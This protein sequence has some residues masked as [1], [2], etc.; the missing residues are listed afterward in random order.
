M[1]KLVLSAALLAAGAAAAQESEQSYLGGFLE[2]SLSDTGRIV[3]VT[4]FEGALSSQARI[5]TLTVADDAGVWLTIEGAVLDWSRSSLLSGALEVNE[6]SAA[7]ITLTR[8]PQAGEAEL[9]APEAGAFSLPELPVSI[10]IGSIVAERITVGESVLGQP[11][12]GHL[13]ATM[14]LADGSGAAHLAL[15][16]T[17]DG[18]LGEIRLD[19]SYD[20]AT[21][22]LGMSLSAAES[23]G[24][25]VAGLLGI[26]GTPATSF[27]MEG[28]G[29]IEAFLADIALSTAGED[30]LSGKATLSGTGDGGHHLL[31]DL[32]GNLAPLFVPEHAEFLG[33]NIRLTLD[34]QRSATGRVM[35]DALSLQARS[36]ALS[37]KGNLAADGLPENFLLS[38]TLA[39][40]DGNP[41]LLPFG[42]VPTRIDRAEFEFSLGQ[43]EATAWQTTARITGLDQADLAIDALSLSGSGTIGRISSRKNFDGSIQLSADG[44]RPTDPSLAQALGE[45]ITGSFRFQALEG[46]KA[47]R[48][49]DL[50]L[51]GDGFSGS[52]QLQIEGL[53]AALLTSGDLTVT[54]D[55]LS[56][57]ALLADRPL[58]GKGTVRLTGSTSLL[59]GALDAVVKVTAQDLQ[60]GIDQIDRLLAGTSTASLSVLR[61]TNGTTIRAFDLTAGSLLA[62][63][64]GTIATAGSALQG[65]VRIGELAMLDPGYGGTA[66]V[67]FEFDGTP[68]A[69]QLSLTGDASNLRLGLPSIDSLL[70]G[71][72][73]LSARFSLTDG[74][75]LIT[76][77]LLSNGQLTASISGEAVDGGQKLALDG[78]LADLGLLIPNLKGPLSLTGTALELGADYRLDLA[79]RGPGKV[80]GKVNGRIA[81]DFST[82]DLT[83]AGTGQAGLA[84]PFIAPRLIDGPL[85][86]DLR[87]NGPL[88]PGSLSGRASLSNGRMSDPGL[89]FALERVDALIDLA[90]GKAKLA[91]TSGLSSG[92]T[93]RV[94]GPV[95][96]A[97]P[98]SADL[99]V[100]LDRIRLFDPNLYETVVQGGLR[101]AGPLTG[102]ALV[103]GDMLLSETEIRVPEAGIDVAGSMI[104]LA[105]LQEPAEVRATRARAGLIGDS[106]KGDKGS[107]LKGAFRLDL[108]INAPGRIFLRGR[109]IDAELGGSLRLQGTSA[110][111]VPSGTFALIR[112]RLDILGKRLTLD[113]ADLKMEGSFVPVLS[114]AAS[115]D[116]DGVTSSVNID[117]PADDPAVTFSSNP[118]LPQEEV[119]A[120]LLFGRGIDSISALQAAQLAQAVA[121][122]AGRGGDGLIGNLRKNFGLDDLDVVTAEDGTAALT[123]GKYISENIYTEVEIE[124]GG[125]SRINLNL[126]LRPGV[127]L[128]GRVG[129]DG[130]TGVGIFIDRDY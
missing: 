64:A 48:L 37:G 26:P 92:G 47:L 60:I 88:A 40:P 23:E 38:G 120:L 100:D 62:K 106:G 33:T 73:A 69:A 98:Y 97:A 125:T 89:G 50:Q 129:A 77:A 22:M 3:K 18:P 28:S 32:S 75:P 130:E 8:L 58:A 42:D 52:G 54:F 105:H 82:A 43:S 78:R 83:I 2:D 72:T 16:R 4:G 113:R 59:S 123:A 119:L 21:R 122:L 86:Y 29:S 56:R 61:D 101:I 99:V 94:E 109:G 27:L 12:E 7:H 87:L 36:L 39:S 13:D 91:V 6:L 15:V 25:L 80:D 71:Q 67:A 20:T 114:L 121:V 46:S 126:D 31:A 41:L 49:S 10:D 96:L 74:V 108:T 128:K 66:G 111:V 1:R 76:S 24:G 30:R 65:T 79:V 55:T 107:A 115:S 112:G 93:L 104:E 70:A 90:A 45:S 35:V 17:G 57:F 14:R 19:A 44:L 116:S 103:S 63:G 81:A 5:A 11:V 9:P 124:Q 34:A 85:R 110:A 127:T 102:G 118:E 51:A 117:G 53:D 68:A 95:A 84:N